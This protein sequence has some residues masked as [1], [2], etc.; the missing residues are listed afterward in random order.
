VLETGPSRGITGAVVPFDEDLGPARAQDVAN[1]ALLGIG[2]GGRRTRIALGSAGYDPVARTVTRA[3]GAPFMQT[4]FRQLML[5]VDGRRSGVTDLAGNRPGARDR[6]PGGDA[7]FRF[8]VFS[9]TT[10]TFQDRDGDRA[11]LAIADG[12]RLDGIRPLRGPA[13]QTTQFWILD[14]IA[15]RSTLSGT[16]RR[17]PR[18][19]GL[20]VIAEIIGLD[21]KEFT[22]LPTNASFRVN[23]LT[24][25]GNA[26]GI[27]R[28]DR[29]GRVE[30]RARLAPA[31][32][33]GGGTG[34][35]WQS[36]PAAVSWSDRPARPARAPVTLPGTCAPCSP[37]P[38]SPSRWSR[39]P[40]AGATMRSG[41]STG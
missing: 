15:P 22:P 17:S 41:S 20:V 29:P 23:T 13:P 7:V 1:D 39:P 2:R 10:V 14:P 9:G 26:T 40:D 28:R 19:D 36:V 30:V 31:V 27:G 25:G 3:A 24:F 5:R 21:K 6:R 38:S 18:G 34:H 8:T 12:G 4:Q 35:G 32:G 33:A 16:V 11:T 37:D